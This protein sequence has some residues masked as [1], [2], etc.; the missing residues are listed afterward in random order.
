MREVLFVRKADNLVFATGHLAY[1]SSASRLTAG[2]AEFLLLIQCREH[3]L[4]RK[5]RGPAPLEG[6]AKY[7]GVERRG[8]RAAP[9]RNEANGQ[10]K[11]RVPWAPSRDFD[12]AFLATGFAAR[13]IGAPQNKR[14]HLGRSWREYRGARRWRGRFRGGGS[15]LPGSRGAMASGA[16]HPGDRASGWCM[17][18]G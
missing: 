17:I 13:R 7:F 12:C 1:S 3:G 6:G 9:L 16:H 18:A 5:T 8:A 15:D 10:H 11:G 14:P 4:R 2:A